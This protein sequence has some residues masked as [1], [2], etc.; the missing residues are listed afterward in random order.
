[1]WRFTLAVTLSLT[2]VTI[3][4][5]TPVDDHCPVGGRARAMGGAS[6]AVSDFWSLG[7]NQAG[8]A[9]LNGVSAGL[10][11][12]N[13]FLLKELM[14]QQTGIVTGTRAGS[15]G[16]SVSYFGSE[17][18]NELMAGLAY[19]KKFGRFFSAGVRLNWMRLHLADEYGNKN[20]I[21]CELGMLFKS[22]KQIT[23]GIHVKNPIPVRILEQPAEYLP[24]IFCM[25][26]SYQFSARFLAV[27]ET[28]KDLQSPMIIRTGLE[29]QVGK[30]ATIRAGIASQPWQVTFGFGLEFGRL[31]LELASGYQQLLGFS[32]SGSLIYNFGRR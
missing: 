11:F 1:M 12:H 13:Q 16:L 27:V 15:F 2:V 3:G 7:N 25:G 30:I 21:S 17:S 29:Y 18:Y 28:E 9:W 26:L 10:C 8:I 19:A 31:H 20:L 14:Y 5:S 22:S 32:P 6:V 23:V 24:V 4:F